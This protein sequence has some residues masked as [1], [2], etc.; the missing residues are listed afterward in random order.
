[1]DE[2]REFFKNAEY[3]NTFNGLASVG[4]LVAAIVSLLTLRLIKKQIRSAQRPNIVFDNQAFGDCYSKNDESFRKLWKNN[5]LREGT[6]L[7][8]SSFI[9][10]ILNVGIGFAEQ[11]ELTE[12]FDMKKAL[13]FIEEN[14]KNNDYLIKIKR[15]I[16]EI[17]SSNGATLKT[18]FLSNRTRHLGNMLPSTSNDSKFNEYIFDDEYLSLLSCCS[19]LKEYQPYLSLEEFP[20]LKIKITF[21]D[22]DGKKYIN[23]FV[24]RP[25]AINPTAFIFTFI[26]K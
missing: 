10:R 5:I 20:S 15:D 22:I 14:D 12:T 17:E 19:H 24:C 8:Y 18:S 1:M 7:N 6:D 9:F 4:T 16:L 26:K 2:I 25:L 11:I 23:H 13:S 21:R 3:L